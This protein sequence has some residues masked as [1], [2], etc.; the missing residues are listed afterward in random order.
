M[1]AGIVVC[2]PG[3]GFTCKEALFERCAAKYQSRGYDVVK[4]DFSHIPFREINTMEEAV[5]ISLRAVKRQLMGI[6]FRDYENVVWISKSFG[7]ILAV[8]SQEAFCI[9]PRHLFLTPLPETLTRIP[10]NTKIIA[11][12]LGTQDRFLSGEALAAFC[13]KQNCC[14][15]LIDGVNHSLKD[16]QSVEHTERI[17]EQIAAFCD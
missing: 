12:V 5:T 9:S 17:I 13:E 2:F 8:L 14:C 6:D 16:E 11:L 4:L 10:P 7:T 3:T 1:K 15:C